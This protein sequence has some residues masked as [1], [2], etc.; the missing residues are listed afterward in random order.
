MNFKKYILIKEEESRGIHVRD[1]WINYS[2]LDNNSHKNEIMNLIDDY[3]KIPYIDARTEL[4]PSQSIR[5]SEKQRSEMAKNASK[6]FTIE[7]RIKHLLKP[8]SEIK[9]EENEEKIKE[10]ESNIMQCKRY[11]EQIESLG[12]V[13]HKSNGKMK[14]S[15]QLGVDDHKD[16]MNKYEEELK[17]LK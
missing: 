15:Y 9:N 13:S 3:K 7:Q 17:K 11:I 12:K 10:L 1:T 8:D 16:K 5:M 2:D 14:T 6:V 4:G